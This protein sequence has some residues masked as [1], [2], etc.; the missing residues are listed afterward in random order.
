MLIVTPA[1][2]RT[3]TDNIPATQE[4]TK[5]SGIMSIF[6]EGFRQKNCVVSGILIGYHSGAVLHGFHACKTPPETK[7]RSLQMFAL[8][9]ILSHEALHLPVGCV[10]SAV[11]GAVLS[12]G[13]V[14]G[15]P[16]PLAAILA[17][18]VHPAASF[19]FLAGSLAAYLLHGMPETMLFL[20]VMLLTVSSLRLLFYEWNKPHLLAVLAVFSGV[21]AG[22]FTEL[23]LWERH[24]LPLYVLESLMIGMGVY[25]TSG[26]VICFRK[27]QK[28]CLNAG[29][30]FVFAMV[31]ILCV[32][33]LCGLHL[34]FCNIGRIAAFT[35]TL[36]AM[37][38]YSCVGGTL[39]GSLSVCG[40]TICSV[41][42]GTPILFLPVIGILGGF[43]NALPNALFL[44]VFFLMQFLSSAVLDSS[45]ELA[46]ILAELLISCTVYAIFSNADFTN[47]IRLSE[48]K[49][50]SARYFPSQESYLAEGFHT[51]REETASIMH[52]LRPLHSPDSLELA[53]TMLCTECR[54]YSFCWE[55][56]REQTTSA[57]R[58]ILENTAC[59]AG[60][61]ILDSCLRRSHLTAVFLTSRYRTALE[62][63]KQN[64][65][66]QIQGGLLQY[67]QIIEEITLTAAMRHSALICERESKELKEIVST[68][69]C[70]STECFVR[71]L[72]CSRY[73]AE[74]YSK[75]SDLP[76]KAI[77]E[78][79][80]SQLDVPMK[81][82]PVQRNGTLYK[83]GFYQT[84]AF[85]LEYEI[86]SVT[87]PGNQRCGDAA[88]FVT[89]SFGNQ[90][91]ILADGMGSGST[92]C[93]A[94]QLAVH[95]FTHMI[96]CGFMPETA[97]R[98][99]NA[100]LL[101]ETS[102]EQFTTLDI[103]RLEADTGEITLFKSGA[104]ATIFCHKG[105]VM[106]IASSSFPVGILSE[107][108]PF[109][110]KVICA[111]QDRVVM[112]SDGIHE[113]EHG[114]IRELLLRNLSLSSLADTICKKAPIY[115]GGS[116]ADDIT[117]IAAGVISG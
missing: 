99:I 18:I 50:V 95:T 108:E 43:L 15:V 54:N 104:A 49:P 53:R 10:L 67:F 70:N 62:Q 36:F 9:K 3:E 24:C 7:V 38:K 90:Y 91:L 22:I 57:F 109:C 30:G 39:C 75:E 27:N 66:Y 76:V 23:F 1:M 28:I 83:Y 58:H 2:H 94:A 56:R 60:P 77:T 101:Y 85:Q 5:V 78:M 21:I 12:S 97:I 47:I 80:S 105:N 61:E 102:M 79:I 110:R 100:M 52:K 88:A 42:L 113:A 41:S 64:H 111:V 114:L 116:Q 115:T 117:V 33:G 14:C 65:L 51:L 34:P 11:A 31:W 72:E 112:L 17:G 63:Q 4:I 84:P 93:L 37:R 26:A 86:C 32:T 20:L 35:A 89:D 107:S 8:R 106:R 48:E 25:V 69:G 92:A 59:A 87:Y 96:S 82:L 71:K 40:A 45:T 98:L 6:Y 19:C 103:L 29:N 74:I 81:S 13:T 73:T 55:H 16:S 46:K 68:C 44:P